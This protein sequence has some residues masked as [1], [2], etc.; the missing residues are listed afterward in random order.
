MLAWSCGALRAGLHPSLDHLGNSLTGHLASLGG[1]ALPCR[2]VVVQLRGDVGEHSSSFGLPG[3][4]SHIGSC[5]LCLGQQPEMLAFPELS[6]EPGP[7][8]VPQSEQSL[9]AAA[10]A[11]ET[12]VDTAGFTKAQWEE[13]L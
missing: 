3:A 13:C 5:C 6:E 2:A 9:A 7:T 11:C 1:T 12:W 4:T 10:N 8:Y